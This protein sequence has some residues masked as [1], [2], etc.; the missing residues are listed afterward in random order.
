MD[1][2]ESFR[3]F[4]A[5]HQQSL[6]RTAYLLAGDAHRA[7]DLLQAVLLKVLGRWSR[8]SRIDNPEAYARKAL[9]N[10]HISWRR[11]LRG[12]A[13]LPSAAPPERSYS[14]EDATVVRLVMRQALM[15]LPPRQRAVIVLRFYEDRTERETAELLNCSIG[16]VKSQAHHALA[17]LR[18]LAP[19]LAPRFTA[20]DDIQEAHR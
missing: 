2:N 20:L 10:Q 8:L 17:R 3:E 11:R 16:T 12:G 9:L 19:E 6:M 1:R 18:V 13:E 7:E 15:R 14:S 4:V 5:A